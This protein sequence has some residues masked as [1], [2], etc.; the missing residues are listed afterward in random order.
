MRKRARGSAVPLRSLSLSRRG[1]G[2]G[3]QAPGATPGPRSRWRRRLWREAGVSRTLRPCKM[4]AEKALTWL[5]AV[6]PLCCYQRGYGSQALCL[7]H[8][9]RP[10]CNTYSFCGPA[11]VRLRA[12]PHPA[13]C[14]GG[15]HARR[16]PVRPRGGRARRRL[17]ALPSGPLAWLRCALRWRL[18]R[19]GCFSRG[20]V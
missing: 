7:A 11:P 19:R 17:R 12:P 1:W 4:W 9:S 16:S 15:A 13:H 14:R 20:K 18:G 10:S 8:L 6:F 3:V 2:E 5:K